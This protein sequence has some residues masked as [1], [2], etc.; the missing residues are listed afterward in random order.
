MLSFVVNSPVRKNQNT[1]H[2]DTFRQLGLDLE[3]NSIDNL[4]CLHILVHSIQNYIDVCGLYQSN[5]LLICPHILVHSIGHYLD[6]CGLYQSNILLLQGYRFRY[7]IFPLKV[8]LSN[9]MYVILERCLYLRD[10]CIRE[11]SVLE[12][13]LY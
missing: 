6:V 3:C 8:R 11:M 9:F 5:I 12:R 1:C 13:C 7:H 2:N 4:M 10:V